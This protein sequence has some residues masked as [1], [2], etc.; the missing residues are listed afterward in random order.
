MDNED[1]KRQVIHPDHYADGGIETIDFTCAKCTPEEFQG[2]C[3][4]NVI[5][6]ISRAGKKGPAQKDI[7]KAF[8]YLGWWYASLEGLLGTDSED[9][10]AP[11]LVVSDLDLAGMAETWK[12]GI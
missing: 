9:Q 7:A 6:Y 1:L 5:R 11:S 8:C 4:S 12:T 10:I 2:A 3:K